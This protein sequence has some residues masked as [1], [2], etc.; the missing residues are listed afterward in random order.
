MAG[1]S[2][3]KKIGIAGLGAIGSAVARALTSQTGI[4]AM[5][6]HAISE[7]AP[8]PEFKVPNVSFA[9]LADQCDLVIECL[10]PHVVPLLTKEVLSKNREMVLI[11]SSALL[12]HPE[13]MDHLRSSKGRIIVPSGALA[14]ID[15]VR[16]LSQVGIKSARIA[17][18]KK[19]A[20]FAGAPFIIEN[21][22]DLSKIKTRQKLFSG[23]AFEAAHGF[24]ANVNVAVT[25]SLAGI[26]PEKT[27]VE[28]WADPEAGGNTHEIHVTSAYSTVNARIE[29]Q[30]DP[31]NP[32]SSVLAAQSIIA[33]LRGMTEPLVVRG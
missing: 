33:L 20:G 3:T 11:S 7:V 26:G 13:I 12:L 23:N 21:N 30:P 2:L 31:A 14:G 24:P 19:P 18:T 6:L 27:E 10:P 5:T 32:R 16:A 17:T 1:T 9:E 28:I 8:K 22:I 4:E 15:A 25:L 29:N